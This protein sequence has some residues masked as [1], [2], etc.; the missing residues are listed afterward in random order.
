MST[1]VLRVDFFPPIGPPY[2][3]R[4]MG[5]ILSVSSVS[6]TQVDVG[7]N[8]RHHAEFRRRSSVGGAASSRIT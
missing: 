1:K 4:L 8:S 7:C 5:D 3:G 2:L 6:M